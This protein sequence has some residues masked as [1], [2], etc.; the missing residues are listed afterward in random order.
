M[1]KKNRSIAIATTTAGRIGGIETYQ[2]DLILNLKKHEWDVYFIIT[3]EPGDYY[4]SL[5]D[6]VT[7]YDLSSIPLSIKKIFLTATLINEISPEILVLNHCPLVNYALPLLS[8]P[9][10]PVSIIHSDDHRFYSAAALFSKRIFRLIA[11][12][13]KLADQCKCYV[14]SN[15]WERIRIIPHGVRNDLFVHQKKK[16]KLMKEI[17]FVGFLGENKG[18]DLLPDILTQIVNAHPA[19]QLNIVGY[20]PLREQLEASFSEKGLSA[21][22]NFTGPLESEGVAEILRKS[23]IFLL[24]TRVEGFGLSIVEAMMSGAVPVISNLAGV[25]DEIVENNI[26]GILVEPENTRMFAEVIIR[27]FNDP[28]R[29]Q[30]MSL[31]ASSIAGAKYAHKR[32]IDDYE[33]LFAERDDRKILKR[34]G[35]IGW[36]AEAINEVIKERVNGRWLMRRAKGIFSKG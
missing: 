32:M 9:I 8:V 15:C 29:L 26:S 31:A 25:T 1:K 21:K 16:E 7:C 18:A 22:C 3:N 11:P 19:V 6:N 33:K 10:K 34:K 4:E 27:L 2:K 23:D 30:T 20:G 13:S 5:K 24:P 14:E 28:T 12:T 17:A 36:Y 35:M